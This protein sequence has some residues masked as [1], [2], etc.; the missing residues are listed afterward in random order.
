MSIQ[1]NLTYDQQ[2]HALPI[3]VSIIADSSPI[4]KFALA[5]PL[6]CRKDAARYLGVA[7][8]TM[9]QWASTGRVLL[10]IVKLGSRKVAYRKADL[11]AFILSNINGGNLITSLENR[12]V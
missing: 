12:H 6:L 3:P 2:K 10:P 9:A 8:Q 11:D 7:S 1:T 4:A 5:S